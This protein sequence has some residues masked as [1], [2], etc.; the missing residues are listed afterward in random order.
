MSSCEDIETKLK[1]KKDSFTIIC[2]HSGN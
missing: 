2:N 1:K